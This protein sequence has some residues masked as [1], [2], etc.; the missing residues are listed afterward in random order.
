MSVSNGR[1]RELALA[2]PESEEQDHWG[3]PSFRVRKKIFATL[4]EENRCVLKLPVEVQR[5]LV[6]AEPETWSAGAWAHQGWTA[7]LLE[8]ISLEDL[9][10]YLV[11]AWSALAPK[12]AIKAYEANSE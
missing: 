7:L 2:L 12:R 4:Q 10:K 9:E 3:Q 5:V 8:K 1:F 11:L 6:A